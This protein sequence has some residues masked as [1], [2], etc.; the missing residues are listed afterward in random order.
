MELTKYQGDAISHNL[1]NAIVS[2]SAGS[3]KTFV[4]I[5][6]IIRLITEENVNVNEIL[7]V[8]FTNLAANEM[9]EKLKSPKGADNKILSIKRI[10]NDR[11]FHLTIL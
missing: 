3:G 10:R 1:G 11:K 9:K 6:R 5:Q 4:V 7:A 8:T 2:A